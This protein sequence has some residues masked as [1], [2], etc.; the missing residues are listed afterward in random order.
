M[1]KF[2][3][4]LSL[5]CVL[6]LS[7]SIKA[8]AYGWEGF[9]VYR[10]GVIPANLQWH[11]GLMD[12]RYI[13]Y[14]DAPVVHTPGS[15]GTQFASW[16]A[17]LNENNTF[18][19]VYKPWGNVTTSQWDLFKAMGRNLAWRHIPY[20]ADRQLYYAT[21]GVGTWVDYNEIKGIRCDGVVEYVY[22]WYG[23]R[24]FGSDTNW[25]ITRASESSQLGHGG[26]NIGPKGQ[27]GYL[28]LVSTEEP[29]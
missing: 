8:H 28:Q 5:T 12:D 16:S 19:G 7:L 27:T 23:F 15:A 13:G 6:I 17:F 25:D 3:R 18:V 24:V 10:D 26:F 20:S 11:A 4:I 21:Y 22:E 1:K 14:T 29:Y 2:K 9:A